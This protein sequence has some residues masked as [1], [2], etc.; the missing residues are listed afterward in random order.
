MSELYKQKASLLLAI[1]ASIA[2]GCALFDPFY[3]MNPPGYSYS[4]ESSRHPREP[5]GGTGT[6]VEVR[7]VSGNDKYAKADFPPHQ[8]PA[9]GDDLL[10]IR[11]NRVVGEAKVSWGGPWLWIMN[12]NAVQGD[13]VIGSQHEKEFEAQQ[14]TERQ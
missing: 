4:A 3:T 6:V 14:P 2:T 12:G 13:L 7:I 5:Y 9:D 1:A 11:T 10:I 8:A